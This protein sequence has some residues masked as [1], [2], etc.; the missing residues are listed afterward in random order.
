MAATRLAEAVQGNMIAVA[1][2]G[3]EIAFWVV[4][5]VGLALRYLTR[6]PRAATVVLL[7][8]PVIDLA[9]LAVTA[10]DLH[11]GAPAGAAHG[12]AAI[13]LGVS[14]AFGHRMIGWADARFAHRFAGAPEPAKPPKYGRAKAAREWKDFG[15]LLIAAV[16]SVGCLFLLRWFAVSP[17]QT[18]MLMGRLPTVAIVLAVWFIVGPLSATLTIGKRDREVSPAAKQG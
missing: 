7:S 12:L 8:V 14:V 16:I 5:A 1:I 9:L 15:L 13:Y 3:C 2:I 18:E 17:Q 11:R 6:K 10:V 4:L